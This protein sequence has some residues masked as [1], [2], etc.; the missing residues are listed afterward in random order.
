MYGE[1]LVRATETKHVAVFAE[2]VDVALDNAPRALGFLLALFLCWKPG[3]WLC[4]FLCDL[5][6]AAIC[7]RH[8]ATLDNPYGDTGSLIGKLERCL[9]VYSVFTEQVGLVT[10]WII[11]K[12]FFSWI[13][14]T[15]K[16]VRKDERERVSWVHYHLYTGGSLISIGFGICFG[17]FAKF[18]SIWFDRILPG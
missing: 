14:R 9:Y 17:E 15:A 16:S 8:K 6:A 12:A 11:L 1:K 5:W 2:A 18:L 3:S 7:K 4:D 10:T 13:D